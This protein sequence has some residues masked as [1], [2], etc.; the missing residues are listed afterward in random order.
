M[1]RGYYLVGTSCYCPTDDLR[2]DGFSYQDNLNVSLAVIAMS[3]NS[4]SLQVWP[5]LWL[6]YNVGPVIEISLMCKY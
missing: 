2:C 4:L 3:L 1:F 5:L 6:T